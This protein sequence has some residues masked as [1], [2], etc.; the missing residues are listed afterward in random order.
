MIRSD[1]RPG[2]LPA[3][4]GPSALVSDVS[5]FKQIAAAAYEVFTFCGKRQR[6][7]GWAQTGHFLSP[8]SLPVLVSSDLLMEQLM[9]DVSWQK[10]VIVA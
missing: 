7:P 2:D 8:T 4:A 6:L 1:A 9:T 3:E 5:S 10:V